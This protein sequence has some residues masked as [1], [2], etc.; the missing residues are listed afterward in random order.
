MFQQIETEIQFCIFHQTET[1]NKFCIF[2]QTETEIQFC[3]FHKI[4]IF[5]QTEFR[6][7]F[8]I[9]GNLSER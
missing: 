3:V 1:K 9:K 7:W 5:N 2:H 6:F 4:L 8:K